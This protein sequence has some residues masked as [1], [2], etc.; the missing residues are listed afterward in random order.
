MRV[1]WSKKALRLEKNMFTP[2]ETLCHNIRV[3]AQLVVSRQIMAFRLFA[4]AAEAATAPSS[5]IDNRA[6]GPDVSR[7]VNRATLTFAIRREQ[8]WRDDR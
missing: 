4:W 8:K 2:M 6:D 3:S 7:P 5:Y 1:V